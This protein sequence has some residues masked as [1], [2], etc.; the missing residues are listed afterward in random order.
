VS[1][2]LAAVSTSETTAERPHDVL[3]LGGTS[4]LGGTVARRAR[5]R[6]HRVTCLARGESGSPP[7]GVTLVAADRSEPGAYDVVRDR[8]WDFVVDVS[9]QPAH[10]RSALAAL[11]GRAGH[12]LFVS[13]LSVY[14]DDTEPGQD[15]DAPL[16]EPWRGEGLAGIDDYGPAKVSCELAVLES[17]PDALV[18]RAG[19]IVGYG[20]RSDR[21]GYW[22][23]RVAR[24]GQGTEVLV[25]PLD[26]PCQVVD[27]EDLAAW[28]V[29][30]GEARTG[31]AVNAMGPTTSLADVLAACA[32]AA[33]SVPEWAQASH[34]WLLE[35]AVEPWMGP[36]SLPL[37]LPQP[38]YEG[39]MTRSR[40]RAEQRG[41]VTRSL[42]ETARAALRWEQEL[43]T[44]RSRHAGLT[45]DDE[46]ELLT[47]LRG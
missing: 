27:V 47:A 16:H 28:L 44:D 14:A 39:F 36:R 4:W 5:D 3:V 30:C 6:G 38:G 23:A 7:T 15:E 19:L 45:P 26:D 12:W 33:G 34:A 42:T 40:Q 17:F 1:G 24:A 8:D 11:T 37:W 35:H 43:G 32:E 46:R 25:P 20:D 18:A 22:P 13:T 21:F 29:R 2:L 31:G 9:R 10:V 41:L